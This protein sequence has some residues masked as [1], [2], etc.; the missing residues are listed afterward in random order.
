MGTIQ[1]LTEKVIGKPRTITFG[2]E[3]FTYDAALNTVAVQKEFA[4]D[5]DD[6]Q[7]DNDSEGSIDLICEH[8]CR[9]ITDWTLTRP[10]GTPLPI[11]AESLD[12]MPEKVLYGLLDELRGSDPK[13]RR[14]R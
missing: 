3:Q 10:D 1:D 13:R 7:A 8:L 12:E 5:L 4:R 2:G 9:L 11:E 6:L 14:R